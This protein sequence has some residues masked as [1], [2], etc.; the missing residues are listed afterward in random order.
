MLQQLYLIHSLNG[1][2]SFTSIPWTH[3]LQATELHSQ[4]QSFRTELTRGSCENVYLFTGKPRSVPPK[5]CVLYH[6]Q[7]MHKTTCAPARVSELW[8]AR[9]RR[10]AFHNFHPTQCRLR[11]VST[12]IYWTTQQAHATTRQSHHI[13]GDAFSEHSS[14]PHSPQ[15][16]NWMVECIC[17]SC[18]CPCPVSILL[19]CACVNGRHSSK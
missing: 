1:H 16:T 3:T 12:C 17:I 2:C 10:Q 7:K 19:F 15:R 14:R 8:I 18:H 9:G 4:L 11:V 6:I 5:L 13:F